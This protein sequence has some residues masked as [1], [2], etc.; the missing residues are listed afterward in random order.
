MLCHAVCCVVGVHIPL[1]ATRTLCSGCW[2]LLYSTLS[3]GALESNRMNRIIGSSDRI[4]FA[5]SAAAALHMQ[6]TAKEGCRM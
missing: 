3:W 5:T 6:A 2:T 1:D 4:E